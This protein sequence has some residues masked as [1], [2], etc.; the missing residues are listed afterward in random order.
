MSITNV[1]LQGYNRNKVNYYL[2]LDE[3]YIV[4]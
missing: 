3:Q 1:N 4:M 2:N